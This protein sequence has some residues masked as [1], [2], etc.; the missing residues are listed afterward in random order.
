MTWL[1]DDVAVDDAVLH[2]ERGRLTAVVRQTRRAAR[3]RT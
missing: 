1:D 2:D 3:R